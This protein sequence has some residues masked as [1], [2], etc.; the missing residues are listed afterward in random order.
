MKLCAMPLSI[1]I[2]KKKTNINI[3]MNYDETTTDAFAETYEDKYFSILYE[4]YY[5]TKE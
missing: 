4:L 3:S 1:Y 2:G 5:L